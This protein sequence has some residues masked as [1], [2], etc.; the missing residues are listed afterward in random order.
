MCLNNNIFSSFYDFTVILLY[1]TVSIPAINV[2]APNT[3]IVGQPL[4]LQCEVTTVRGITS[5]VDIVW[6]SGGTVLQRMNNVPSTMMSN[7]LVYINSYTIS[8]LSA[9]DE[10]RVIQCE[11]VINTNPPVMADDSVT[12]DVTG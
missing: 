8:Q 9:T 6:S 3:Q 11:V 12:L 4:T 1:I 10:V 2:I 7:S 5:R